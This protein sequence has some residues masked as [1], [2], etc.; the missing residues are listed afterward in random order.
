M[1]FNDVLHIWMIDELPDLNWRRAN[2]PGISVGRDD[3]GVSD[4]FANSGGVHLR[5]YTDENWWTEDLVIELP[6]DKLQ[7]YISNDGMFGLAFDPDCH[8]YNDGISLIITTGLYGEFDNPV[9]EPVTGLGVLA[10]LSGLAG[11]LRKR[12][13]A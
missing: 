6:V 2:W 12:K 3:Q 9:P 1:E 5:D 10:G 8:Y 4:A 11:Y 7:E 13:S